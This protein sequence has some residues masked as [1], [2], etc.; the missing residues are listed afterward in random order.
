MSENEK[1]EQQRRLWEY[2]KPS[3]K[4]NVSDDTP[5]SEDI[6][7]EPRKVEG[8]DGLLLV[9]KAQE[10][11]EAAEE[12]K[13]QVQFFQKL[14]DDWAANR[15]ARFEQMRRV[16]EEQKQ[17]E[18]EAAAAAEKWE[19]DE[20]AKEIG[21]LHREKVV[22]QSVVADNRSNRWWW[23]VGGLLLSYM[24]T[25]PK[26]TK[27]HK[28]QSSGLGETLEKAAIP[29]V[30]GLAINGMS[31]APAN[32]L[33]P[34]LPATVSERRLL[35]D[36]LKAQVAALESQKGESG[37]GYGILGMLVGGILKES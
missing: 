25:E 1:S 4:S 29:A 31:A 15:N 13:K 3:K 28:N 30:V 21:Q 35:R 26:K 17:R 32:P 22:L 24:V 14:A 34:M 10:E 16:Q 9:K 18:A 23:G 33:L 36:D 8:F 19:L 27:R 11:A 5:S 12:E 6:K 20:L 37:L 2:L 7:P